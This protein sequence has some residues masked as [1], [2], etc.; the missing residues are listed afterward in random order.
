V[1]AVA[2]AEEVKELRTQLQRGLFG[3][4]GVLEHRKVQVP[5]GGRE[6]GIAAKG[7]GRRLHRANESGFSIAATGV[8]S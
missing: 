5:P 2:V 8:L 4:S 7:A 3:Q 6:E 1:Q